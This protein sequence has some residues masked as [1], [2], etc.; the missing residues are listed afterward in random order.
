M[1]CVFV[2]Q[3]GTEVEMYVAFFS[4]ICCKINS[5]YEPLG[6]RSGYQWIGYIQNGLFSFLLF[7]F[8]LLKVLEHVANSSLC[9]VNKQK[10]LL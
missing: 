4:D 7:V 5:Y 8:K 9:I 6:G 3:T 1:S 10:V 2:V